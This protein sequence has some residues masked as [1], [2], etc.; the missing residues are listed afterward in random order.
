MRIICEC[1]EMY[2]LHVVA[3]YDIRKI[4]TE[5]D[6]RYTNCVFRT[7]SQEFHV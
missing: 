4:R 1:I 5:T 2:M 3:A 6:E 7:R